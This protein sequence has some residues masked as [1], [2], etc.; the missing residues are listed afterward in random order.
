[1]GHRQAAVIQP[2]AQ[3]CSKIL[4]FQHGIEKERESYVL[5]NWGWGGL[6]NG[7]FLNK[8]FNASAGYVYPDTIPANNVRKS[9][10]DYNY[11]YRIHADWG[12]RI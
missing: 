11:K 12:V 7:Y 10:K 2:T 1:M 5:C 8:V 9:G 3:E 6:H 4:V